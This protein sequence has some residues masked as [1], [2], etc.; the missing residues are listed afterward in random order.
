MNNIKTYEWVLMHVAVG[1]MTGIVT[2]IIYD[3]YICH[4]VKKVHN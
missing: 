2:S 1:I 4:H 3:R